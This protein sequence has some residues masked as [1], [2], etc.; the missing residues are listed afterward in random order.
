VSLINDMLRDLERRDASP[1]LPPVHEPGRMQDRN[2]GR[3]LFGAALVSVVLAGTAAFWLLDDAAGSRSEA[4]VGNGA[5][6]ALSRAAGQAVSASPTDDTDGAHRNP[7]PGDVGQVEGTD[8]AGES[9]TP[10]AAPPE[11]PPST[12]PRP[13]D[14]SDAF[15]S[16][17]TLHGS[18]GPQPEASAPAPSASPEPEVRAKREEAPEPRI[19]IRRSDSAAQPANDQLESARRALGRGQTGLAVTRLEEVLAQH[20]DDV[21]ARLLLARTHFL[22]RRTASAERVLRAGL[23]RLPSNPDL[24]FWLGRS[25]LERGRAEEAAEILSVLEASESKQLHHL[26][27]IGAVHRSLG[28]HERALAVYERAASLEPDSSTAWLGRALSLEQ[29]GRT[30]EALSAYRRIAEAPARETAALARERIA[31]LSGRRPSP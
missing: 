30:D 24:A 29:L 5:V 20:P 21:D 16:A 4:A 14:E 19:R 15:G 17:P 23:E 3:L 6:P 7:A 25:L 1:P 31:A 12:Q 8:R 18:G 22:D 13:A 9:R 28:R 27:L 11:A 26:L 2:R 10:R